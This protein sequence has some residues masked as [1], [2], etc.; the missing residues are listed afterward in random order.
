MAILSDLA[1]YFV[2]WWLTLFAILPIGLRTQDEDESVVPGTVASA[3]T[4]FRA[5][6]VMLLTTLVS[7][8]I[9]GAWLVAENYFGWSFKDLPVFV[10]GLVQQ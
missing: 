6:R 2:V 4:R 7:G 8:A 5:G 1:V 9:F 3:P 10:P